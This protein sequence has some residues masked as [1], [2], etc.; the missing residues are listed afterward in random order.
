MRSNQL[1]AVVMLL[2]AGAEKNAAR[3]DGSTA[4]HLAA[5]G[6]NL[7]MTQQLV[8]LE[9]DVARENNSG[10]TAAALARQYG[11][12]EVADAIAPR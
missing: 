12:T 11:N 6:G 3:Y 8:A 1:S 4:L 9:V 10:V 5:M 2:E 7:E